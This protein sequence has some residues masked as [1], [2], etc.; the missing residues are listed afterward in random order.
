MVGG[1]AAGATERLWRGSNS[2]DAGGGETAGTGEGMEGPDR[3]EVAARAGRLVTVERQE[4]L[5][6]R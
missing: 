2:R 4:R 5:E 3:W 1:G 6:P